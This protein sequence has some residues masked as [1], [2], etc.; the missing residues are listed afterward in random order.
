MVGKATCGNISHIYPCPP[1]LTC[2]GYPIIRNYE[3]DIS[4]SDNKTIHKS[5]LAHLEQ[6]IFLTGESIVTECKRI[7]Q[8]DGFLALPKNIQ[9]IYTK[10]RDACLLYPESVFI[11]CNVELPFCQDPNDIGRNVES[12]YMLLDYPLDPL[13]PP[14]LE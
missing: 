12:P 6:F 2:Y 9:T 1:L 13:D 5:N 10:L 3:I 14:L 8:T 4:L 11:G 7:F